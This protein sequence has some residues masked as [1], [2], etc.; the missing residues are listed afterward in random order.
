MP[1]VEVK[2]K[3]VIEFPEGMSKEEMEFH[4]KSR[5]PEKKPDPGLWSL[6][7]ETAK[8]GTPGIGAIET[9]MQ[10]GTGMVSTPI[11][12]L[13]GLASMPWK[14]IEGGADLMGN[15]QQALTYEPRTEFGKMGSQAF[16]WPQAKVNEMVQETG[17]ELIRYSPDKYGIDMATAGDV[18]G[19]MLMFAMESPAFKAKVQPRLSTKTSVPPVTNI[20]EFDYLNTPTYK[21]GTFNRLADR[22][23]VEPKPL[24]KGAKPL[25]VE[26]GQGPLITPVEKVPSPQPSVKVKPLPMGQ[27]E[28]D[29][30]KLEKGK[31]VK[32][33][34]ISEGQSWKAPKEQPKLKF[35][36]PK[37]KVEVFHPVKLPKSTKPVKLDSLDRPLQVPESLQTKVYRG[38][39]QQADDRT[40]F[41]SQDEALL[42]GDAAG[43]FEVSLSK[44]YKTS[45][46]ITSSSIKEAMK[47]GADGIMSTETGEVLPFNPRQSLKYIREVKRQAPIQQAGLTREELLSDSVVAREYY[48]I[49]EANATVETKAGKG[50]KTY[51]DLS[52]NYKFADKWLDTE[53]TKLYQSSKGKGINNLEDLIKERTK[54]SVWDKLNNEQGGVEL[55]KFLDELKQ[56]AWKAG[57]WRPTIGTVGHEDLGRLQS[58][59]RRISS[60]SYM[61]KVEPFPLRLTDY[62]IDKL[63]LTVNDLHTIAKTGQG[64]NK[65]YRQAKDLAKV[66]GYVPKE[67]SFVN[68]LKKDL[69]H[70]FSKGSMGEQVFSSRR[71][72]AKNV[73][74]AL[75]DFELETN[76][77]RQDKIHQLNQIYKGL[78]KDQEM[79][80]GK[81]LDKYQTLSDV[82]AELVKQYP[83]EVAVMDAVRKTIF[84]DMWARAGIQG[85]KAPKYIEN[86]FTRVYKFEGLD[87]LK[88]DVRAKAIRAFAAQNKMDFVTAEKVLRGHIPSSGFFGPFSKHRIEVPPELESA[89]VWD[90]SVVEWYINGAARYIGLKKFLP[91]ANQNLNLLA[92]NKALHQSNVYT[93]LREHV[94]AARGIPVTVDMEIG[95][96]ARK[97]A[98]VEGTR[99]YI[100]KMGASVAFG[101]TNLTQYP[102]NSGIHIFQKVKPGDGLWNF[103]RG[104]MMGLTKEGHKLAKLSGITADIGK[105]EMSVGDIHGL[106][107]KTADVLGVFANVSERFNKVAEFNRVWPDL[108]KAGKAKG[109]GGQELIQWA[110]SRARY[111]V[112]E[113]QFLMGAGDRPISFQGPIGS[114]VGK[115]KLFT[116]KQLEFIANLRGREIPAFLAMNQLIGGPDAIGLDYLED[117]LIDSKFKD[118]DGAQAFFQFMKAMRAGSLSGQTGWDLTGKIGVGFFPGLEHGVDAWE[119]L[120]RLAM[121][122]SGQDTLNFI[123]DIKEGRVASSLKDFQEALFEGHISKQEFDQIVNAWAKAKGDLVVMPV[124]VKRGAKA[125]IENLTEVKET[126]FGERIEPAPGGMETVIGYPSSRLKDAQIEIGK[127]QNDKERAAEI[128]KVLNAEFADAIRRQ[129]DRKMERVI[130]QVADFNMKYPPLGVP[131][132]WPE[133][134]VKA[135]ANKNQEMW[136]RAGQNKWGRSRLISKGLGDE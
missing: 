83:K 91:M 122:V 112:A 92:P 2:G 70:I 82:P 89:R 50:G 99:Q 39:R 116:I 129:H 29:L 93:A 3:G 81:L 118:S 11:A 33:V 57:K 14:G 19:D 103:S 109:L 132:I 106:W 95:N 41:M 127:L 42:R 135:Y 54:E 115:F 43:E 17:S 44:V 60:P 114:T 12:G 6:V 108:L 5:W 87:Q 8:K 107:R 59:K 23:L 53:G 37:P 66:A 48:K 134:L 35:E 62:L 22:Q 79:V 63:G 30:G 78:N 49:A 85:E 4:I 126:R 55:N 131:P 18:A 65:L 40:F 10:V 25:K 111:S 119:A 36:G 73:S 9:A 76:M 61:A 45:Q 71:G 72:A 52:P 80:V 64:S 20:P 102:L 67:E 96:W 74:M 104:A 90:K 136:W 68:I 13:V 16:S 101:I 56:G 21:P 121:P 120:G 46:P 69:T 31:V 1:R 84:D 98:R 24:R 7:K 117:E 77:L 113:H 123:T 94:D 88:P 38:A 28:L 105:G 97:A 130:R 32:Q 86:Y 15:I 34:P 58:L 133:N 51:T 47:V 110:T 128:R 27:L 100:T 125:Y 26:P 75:I 124:G